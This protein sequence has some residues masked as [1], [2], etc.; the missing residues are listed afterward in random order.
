V[1][2]DHPVG[3]RLRFRLDVNP[4]KKIVTVPK[5]ARTSPDQRGRHGRRVPVPS[6]EE[7]LREWLD[8]RAAAGGFRV[9]SLSLILPGYVYANKTRE[10]GKGHRLRSCR[11][12]GVL[13]VTDAGAFRK[14][15]ASGIGPAK[16]YGFGLLSV[17]PC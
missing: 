11:Y 1:R 17:A 8:F 5:K 6:T 2:L 15:L 12:E 14:T 3:A 7:S 13:Q 16:A 9:E 4:T 10:P